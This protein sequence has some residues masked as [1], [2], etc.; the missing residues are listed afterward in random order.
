[1][2]KVL[3]FLILSTL[4]L[5]PLSPL[6][7]A[8]SGVDYYI[9]SSTGDDGNDGK[10]AEKPFKTF[11]NINT[12]HL[13]AGDRVLLKRGDE[14]NQRLVINGSGTSDNWI[15]VAPY[16]SLSDAAPTISLNNEK[17]DICILAT[18]L[19]GGN[20]SY[21]SLNYIHIDGLNISNSCL[22]IYFRYAV[23][24]D[25]RGIMVTDCSFTNINCLELMREALT[26]TEFLTLGKDLPTY[27]GGVYSASGG[28]AYE[29]IWPSAI[30]IG[31]RPQAA[32]ASVTIDGKCRPCTKV[33]D[34]TISR[35]SLDN[36][37]CGIS[38][39]AYAI[40]YGWGEEHINFEYTANW[41]ITDVT[42]ISTMTTL[43]IDSADFG[44]D[45]TDSS[46]WG[47]FTNLCHLSGMTDYSMSAGTTCVLISTT[48]NLLIK[49]SCFIGCR[50]NGQPDGCGFDFE[51]ENH[52]VTLKNCII[53]ENEGQGVLMMQTTGADQVTGENIGSP[54]TDCTLDNCLFYDNMRG[55][56]NDN[57]RY[58]F[59]VFNTDNKNI[60]LSGYHFVFREY[61]SGGAKVLIDSSSSTHFKFLPAG[62]VKAGISVTDA[63]YERGEQLPTLENAAAAK[64][65]SASLSA[66]LPEQKTVTEEPVTTETETDAAEP[67][68]EQTQTQPSDGGK[69]NIIPYVIGGAVVLLAVCAIIAAKIIKK[70]RKNP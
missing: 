25:N 9:S 11:D 48:K 21:H 29:Y 62:K 5:T 7:R 31:G 18:D 39:N 22:G 49:D 46:H 64:G 37:V 8:V 66:S 33:S 40:H 60:V 1:M 36:C 65:L 55:V 3:S 10:S 2:K 24:E 43:N 17:N 53:A 45:G 69:T 20:S 6:C 54:N 61:T 12:L 56:Y 16:G 59:T 30:N 34:I 19:N 70:P 38:A 41:K 52:N 67:T 15:C 32:M 35:I 14:W 27:S 47:V 23:S 13:S 57:Y 51:R 42:S 50:N 58:D 68:A 28:G 4:L 63:T 26:T 44:Y